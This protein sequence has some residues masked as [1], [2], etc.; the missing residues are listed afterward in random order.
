MGGA[1]L[2]TSSDD[3]DERQT[4]GTAAFPSSMR[5]CIIRRGADIGGMKADLGVS[6]GVKLVPDSVPTITTSF[7]PEGDNIVEC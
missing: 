7:P 6:I 2:L 1:E 5:R 3:D 4:T